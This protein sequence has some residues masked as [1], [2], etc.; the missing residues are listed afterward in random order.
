M[1]SSTL[2]TLLLS[3]SLALTTPLHPRQ[4][5]NGEPEWA[6][7]CDESV[8]MSM[9]CGK[10]GVPACTGPT[11]PDTNKIPVDCATCVCSQFPPTI[12]DIDE[13]FEEPSTALPA[14]GVA[15]DGEECHKW[16]ARL[17][18]NGALRAQGLHP[19]NVHIL[20][21]DSHSPP[22][23]WW[24]VFGVVFKYKLNAANIDNLEVDFIEVASVFLRQIMIRRFRAVN[25]DSGGDGGTDQRDFIWE[26]IFCIS[27][28]NSL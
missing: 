14:N 12:N 23:S 4:D 18:S 22:V 17:A 8:Q 13:P 3:A 16:N 15:P 20:P 27:G 5:S 10:N 28:E 26:M 1:L 6:L 24:P 25:A 19:A 2:L 9:W 21:Y 11:H 7:N